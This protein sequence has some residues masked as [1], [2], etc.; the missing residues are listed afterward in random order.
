MNN[1]LCSAQ[2]QCQARQTAVTQGENMVGSSSYYF[3]VDGPLL[4]PPPYGTMKACGFLGG[5]ETLVRGHGGNFDDVIER[6]GIHRT[7]VNDDDYA[8][9][10]SSAAAMLDYC[11]VEFDDRLFG[12]RLGDHLAADLYGAITTFARVAPNIQQAIDALIEYMPVIYCP[13]ADVEFLMSEDVAEFR[14]LPSTEFESDEQANYLGQAQVVRFLQSLIGWDFR[15]ARIHVVSQPRRNDIE[16]M[17]RFFGCKVFGNSPTNIVSFP[18]NVVHRRLRTANAML[19]GLL[20][21]YF[22]QVKKSAQ[23]TFVDMVKS[24]VRAALAT[25]NCTIERCAMKMDASPRTIQRRLTEQGLRFSE[26]IEEQ[27]VEAAK[28]ALTDTGDALASIAL[29]LGY[30]DQSSFGRAFKRWTGVTPQNFRDRKG[31][32]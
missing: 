7:V 19:F 27:R 24:Y 5:I 3:N 17:Q 9:R 21:S 20:G 14:W 31:K 10:C 12:L 18:A 25:G 11:S 15:P 13:G 32:T 6:Y 8:I 22:A 4:C 16:A 26:I 30:S 1:L 2:T 28:R 29:N 23:H